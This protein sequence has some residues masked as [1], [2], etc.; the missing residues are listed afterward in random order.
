[1]LPNTPNFNLLGIH[2]AIPPL[3]RPES[4]NPTSQIRIHISSLPLRLIPALVKVA[5]NEEVS[6]E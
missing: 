1:M 5:G 3:S 6:K 2:S 4:M